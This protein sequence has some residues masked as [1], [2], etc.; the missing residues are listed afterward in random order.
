M[1][2]LA[3]FDLRPADSVDF[4]AG[5][6]FCCCHHQDEYTDFT[7]KLLLNIRTAD[8]YASLKDNVYRQ[9]E[10]DAASST[11]L[12]SVAEMRGLMESVFLVPADFFD[13]RL[14]DGLHREVFVA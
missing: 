8:G 3:S 13:A 7:H 4:L 11:T 5:C 12:T 6:H 1:D 10:G 9:R 14:L 2:P